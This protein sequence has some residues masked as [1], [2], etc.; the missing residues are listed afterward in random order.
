[1]RHSAWRLPALISLLASLSWVAAGGRAETRPRYGGT[2]NVE[3]HDAIT[4]TDPGDWPAQLVPLVYD[5][6]VQ[7]DDRGEP[8]PALAISWQ[9]D[10]ENKRW[11]LHLRPGVKFHD[12]SPLNAA[13]VAASL[14]GRVSIA[15]SGEDAVII[16]T[17]NPVPDLLVRLADP[18][19][20]V[21]RRGADGVTLGSGPFR[22]AEWQPGR[23]ALLA[24]NDD[25]WGGRPFLDSIELQMGRLL[26]DQSIDLELGKADVAE[27][28][29]EDARRAA[30]RGVRVWTSAPAELLA[31]VFES[32][33]AAFE[34]A[35]LREAVALSI[36]RAAI[37]NVLLQRQ[38]ESTAALLPEWLTGFAFLFPAS[39]DLERARRIAASRTKAGLRT[40]LSYDPADPLA[41]SIAERIAVDVREA[42]V[43]LQAMPGGKADMRLAR[44]QLSSLDPLQALS[45]FAAALALPAPLKLSAGSAPEAPYQAERKLLENY[46]VVPLFHVAQIVGLGP[47]VHNWDSRPWGNWRLDGVWLEARRP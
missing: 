42:G 41:R 14:K 20:A 2:L 31:L 12:G 34:D 4:F 25:Y 29:P 1:M 35:H 11:E 36:D 5:R 13:S 18:R 3:I 10:A 39:R 28:A 45:D 19:A 38:G 22:I 37:H 40:T 32:G 27:L 44:A 26:R 7:L 47:Q 23:R 15:M 16:Q 6:L 46:R 21:L 8:R 33:R 43:V 24:A 30:Q 9:H 17:E